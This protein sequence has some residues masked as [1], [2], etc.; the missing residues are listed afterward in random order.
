MFYC[1]EMIKNKEWLMYMNLKHFSLYHKFIINSSSIYQYTLKQFF[2]WFSVLK[3]NAWFWSNYYYW[4]IINFSSQFHKHSIRFSTLSSLAIIKSEKCSQYKSLKTKEAW[5]RLLIAS[6]NL[7]L[8]EKL[9]NNKTQCS[10]KTVEM[11][12]MI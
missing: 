10:L 6:E 3:F 9:S 12:K 1:N 8:F 7:K 2:I 5:E 11:L 4:F